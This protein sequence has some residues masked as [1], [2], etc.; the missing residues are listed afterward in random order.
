M[1]PTPPLSAEGWDE[2][3]DEIANP[4]PPTPERRRTLERVRS[5]RAVLDEVELPDGEVAERR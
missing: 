5:L 2:I 3:M 1:E 4:R